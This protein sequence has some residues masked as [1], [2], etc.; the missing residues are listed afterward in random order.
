MEALRK[1]SIGAR[2]VFADAKSRVRSNT[3][4]ARADDA[5]NEIVAAEVRYETAA[6]SGNYL[7]VRR[8][9][10][11][12]P[13]NL[14]KAEMEAFYTQRMAHDP[15]P[16]RHYYDLILAGVRRCPRCGHRSVST[17]DHHL[18][19]AKY[20]DLVVTPMNLVPSCF[21]CNRDKP[22]AVPRSNE[23][24]FLH[25]YFEDISSD[26][27]LTARSPNP[28]SKALIFEVGAPS[29]WSASL[30]ARVRYQFRELHLASL[31]S[32]QAADEV[33]LLKEELAPYLARGGPSRVQG[34]VAG[35][36]TGASRGRLNSWQS[37]AFTAW[38]SNPWFYSGGFAT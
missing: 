5:M 32:G 26:A 7:K 17:L 31:Y 13:G 9:T 16:A 23:E 27:W 12:G 20:I 25:P 34:V 28:A 2:A 14:T 37:A 10:T 6:T 11:V 24:V 4:R 30:T 21:D 8:P 15:S 36:A 33:V 3:L 1:P 19:K 18:P 38:A 22:D 35:R 29:T